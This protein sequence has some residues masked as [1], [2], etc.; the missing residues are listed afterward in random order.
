M[1]KYVITIIIL[2]S[3]ILFSIG[4]YFIYSNAKTNESNSVDTL[5]SKGISE[6]EYL[7]LDIISMMNQIN[8][9][10]YSNFKIKNEE[11]TNFNED[12]QNSIDVENSINSSKIEKNGILIGDNSKVNWNE[13]K[14]KIE[15]MYSTWTTVMMDLSTLN[16][17]K[18]NL[19]K[20]NNILDELTKSF[21]K[22]DKKA[23]LTYLADL[24]NL[25]SLYLKDFSNDNKIISLFVVKTYIL[26][27][28]SYSEQDN[29]DKVTDCISKGKQEF[30]NILNNQI[31]NVNDIDVIN[32]SY[33]LINELEK[34]GKNKDKNIFYINY[35]N[36][37]QELENIG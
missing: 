10:S 24:H 2:F 20:Y 12:Q 23:S 28:Y 33:I 16:V 18:E 25:L 34:N 4:G 26:Y 31:N 37:M 6:I 19:T 29:W 3:I 21:E 1:K 14:S 7:S 27:S 17:N 11:I 8:N 32:K 35:S 22:E 9:I 36:L 5:K 13:L 30:L 15:N